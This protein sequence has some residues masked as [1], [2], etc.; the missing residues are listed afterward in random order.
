MIYTKVSIHFYHRPLVL[1]TE[2]PLSLQQD[3]LKQQTSNATLHRLHPTGVVSQELGI[4]T[5]TGTGGGYPEQQQYVRVAW[6]RGI[7]RAIYREWRRP[8][9]LP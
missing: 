5:G 3:A 2:E 1:L 9:L 6:G 7:G 8:G 4:G